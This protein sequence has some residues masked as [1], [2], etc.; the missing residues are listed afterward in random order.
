M[1]MCR[2][3]VRACVCVFMCVCTHV[4][5][6]ISD[7]STVYR[8]PVAEKKVDASEF[9]RRPLCPWSWEGKSMTGRVQTW[10]SLIV[11]GSDLSLK[12][13]NTGTHR[14]LLSHKIRF[15]FCKGSWEVQ[16]MKRQEISWGGS[17]TSPGT[18]FW[19]QYAISLSFRLGWW[20]WTCI[21]AGT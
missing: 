11:R 6:L 19:E 17:C 3:C 16:I 18:Y 8:G 15:A 7:G 13:T 14:R 21:G 20:Q 4:C 5:R 2:W 1:R 10:Q 9:E 12:S